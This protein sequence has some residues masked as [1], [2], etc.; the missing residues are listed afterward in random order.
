MNMIMIGY[1][2]T[3]YHLGDSTQA[4]KVFR[5]GPVSKRVCNIGRIKAPNLPE[6]GGEIANTSSFPGKS[7][8]QKLSF[9]IRLNIT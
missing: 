1:L 5:F 8:N 6:R 9:K 7:K 4:K 2:T 3:T